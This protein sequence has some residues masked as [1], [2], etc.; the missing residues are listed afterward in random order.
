M[1][2][3]IRNY[4]LQ[5]LGIGEV[6]Q[7]RQ[8]DLSN[9]SEVAS[10][11]S[12]VNSSKSGVG[13]ASDFIPEPLIQ[14][15]EAR[16]G[17]GEF[18]AEIRRCEKCPQCQMFGKSED[19]TTSKTAAIDVVVVTEYAA[20]EQINERDVLLRNVM[21]ALS[22]GK[23]VRHHRCSVF[24]AQEPNTELHDS[25]AARNHAMACLPFLLEE[26]ELI[27]PRVILLFGERVASALLNLAAQPK[28]SDLR[29]I[30]QHYQN[31]PVIVT[32]SFEEMLSDP[33]CKVDV[34][35]DLCQLKTLL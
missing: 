5:N 6:W 19:Q 20:A 32:Y 7:L 14:I 3:D 26:I 24:K 16:R 35:A 4:Y 2:N 29:K 10:T 33:N 9:K 17:W 18:F 1:M 23:N 34:W 13:L 12:I 8:T 11:A 30:Q 22:I 31:I 27:Q 25:I 21:A 28:I 15:N